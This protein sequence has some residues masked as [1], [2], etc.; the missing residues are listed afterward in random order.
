MEEQKKNDGCKI[1]RIKLEGQLDVE[2]KAWFDGFSIS[3]EGEDSTVLTGE[4]IDDA[5]LHG[6]LKKIRDL[7]ITLLS[8]N[9]LD[10]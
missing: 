10:K 8:I 5:A 7:G 1:Y 4:I 3:Y 9:I 6:I 2:W